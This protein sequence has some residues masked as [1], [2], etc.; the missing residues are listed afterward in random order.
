ML[1]LGSQSIIQN[2]NLTVYLKIPFIDTGNTLKFNIQTHDQNKPFKNS[3]FLIVALC[4][5][6]IHCLM[7]KR[8][9]YL[10]IVLI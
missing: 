10:F 7:I 8:I 3:L 1:S 4:F 2:L 5:W 9:L 6:H